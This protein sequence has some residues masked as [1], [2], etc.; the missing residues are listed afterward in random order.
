M[1]SS[2]SGE[3][4]GSAVGGFFLGWFVS[5]VGIGITVFCCAC[6]KAGEQRDADKAAAAEHEQPPLPP[7]TS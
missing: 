7:Y 5:L 1:S 6:I 2:A 3:Q 4:C